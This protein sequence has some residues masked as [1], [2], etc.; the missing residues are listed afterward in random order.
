M[1]KIT[2]TFIF[3]LSLSLFGCTKTKDINNEIIKE[4]P[5]IETSNSVNENNIKNEN[6]DKDV[7][8][9]EKDVPNTSKFYT[10]DYQDN[11]LINAHYMYDIDVDNKEI[12]IKIEYFSNI[13]E[14]KKENIEKT[15]F[16]DDEDVFNKIVE[17]YEK[18]V[19]ESNWIATYC[20][21]LENIDLILNDEVFVT[22]ETD[23]D[24]WGPI[25]EQYDVNNDD[26][27]TYREN[28]DIIMERMSNQLD[29]PCYEN[30]FGFSEFGMI[31]DKP[32]IYLY[33]QEETKVNVTLDYN[34]EFT[35]TY[36]QYNK[37]WNMIAKPN[38]TLIDPIT[39]KEY[40]CLFWEGFSNI[41]YD[42][43]KGFV[44]KGEDTREF[45]ENSL[46]TLGL[47]EREM[48]EFIIFWLPK[49]EHNPYNLI[50]FQNESY[51][52]NAMLNVSPTPDSIIRVFMVWKGLDSPIDIA[53]Q[54]LQT[55]QRDGFV[56]V[57]WGGREVK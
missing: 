32:V 25:Y 24:S 51:T 49:M 34:G 6:V 52:N 20:S 18:N 21:T 29:M 47:S 17:V 27:V 3:L 2:Y 38:G 48:N 14:N 19:I 44:V 46:A 40:Y 39:N 26:I 1:R 54:E 9:K 57:E 13:I 37:G 10:I 36:P 41:E 53:P 42:L 23:S 45:L 43:S 12:K 22:K 55:P 4:E 15:V 56:V 16:V 30:E 28:F 11:N 7:N 8:E 31:D 50:T 35:T 33:P 5:T